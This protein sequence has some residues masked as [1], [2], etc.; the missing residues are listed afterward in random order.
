ML[1]F[2]AQVSLEDGLARTIDWMREHLSL[3]D[4]CIHRHARHMPLPL[5]LSAEGQR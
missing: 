4:A 2:E 3:I 5:E 1:G